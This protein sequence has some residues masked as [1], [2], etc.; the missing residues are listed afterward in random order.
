MGYG[1]T[2]MVPLLVGVSTERQSWLKVFVERED[3]GLDLNFTILEIK[4][5]NDNHKIHEQEFH[6]VVGDILVLCLEKS[7]AKEDSFDIIYRDNNIKSLAHQREL[8]SK[9]ITIFE[10]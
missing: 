8:Q 7:I 10:E 1:F 2:E 6:K 4:S 5:D 3:G 9:G